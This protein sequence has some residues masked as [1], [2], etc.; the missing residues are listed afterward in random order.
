MN[1]NYSLRRHLLLW[2]SLPIVVVTLLALLASYFSAKH[3]VEEIYDAQLVHS[4]KVLLQLTQH[5]I[6]EDE[7]FDLGIEDPSLQHKYE[8]NFGYRIWFKD[9][10]ISQSPN[11]LGFKDF[12]APPKFSDQIIN[13]KEWRFFVFVDPQ[14]DIKIEV[15]EIYDIRYELILQLILSLILPALA[16]LPIILIVIWVGIKK[17]LKPVISISV[18]VDQR[19]S[20]DLSPI[21]RTS[22]PSEISPLIIALNRL[23]QRIEDSFKR[24]KEFTDNAAHEL[25]TPLA[26]MKTQ[27]QVLLKKLDSSKEHSEDLHN[28]N[29]SIDRASHMVDQLLS[30]SRL[31]TDA[32]EFEAVNL[33][34]LCESVLRELSLH[35]LKKDIELEADITPDLKVRGHNGSL[36]IMLR[37]FVGN[38][39]KFTPSSGKISVSLH[40]EDRRAVLRV[41]DTGIGI[42]DSDKE[43]VFERFYRVQKNKEGTG[44]GLAMAKWVVDMH[45]AVISLSDNKP[46]GLIITVTMEAL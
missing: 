6:K 30:F 31:Q 9:K 4:A 21:F 27:T 33:S 23:F 42:K 43:K 3:E 11:T 17:V 20:N 2:I 26:A 8:R 12:E 1:T 32:I 44:L 36:E 13:G 14:N 24:E 45:K 34:S 5:E 40:Q 41:A 22:L 29:A 7:E 18:E 16:F 15:S 35:S 25:R 37:N 39:I 46:S 38:S 19:T 28:L 10:I